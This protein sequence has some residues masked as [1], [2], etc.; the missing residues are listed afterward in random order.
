ME[1]GLLNVS[2]GSGGSQNIPGTA[3]D[4]VQCE[5]ILGHVEKG[6]AE[7]VWSSWREARRASPRVPP[8]SCLR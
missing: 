7:A 4:A 3:D 2:R 8:Y 5:R 1:A 6:A